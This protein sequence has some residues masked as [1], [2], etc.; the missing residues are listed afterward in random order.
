MALKN[1]HGQYMAK[2]RNYVGPK[3][4][5]YIKE[6]TRWTMPA[7]GTYVVGMFRCL[8]CGRPFSAGLTHVMSGK[9]YLCNECSKERARIKMSRSRIKHHEGDYVGNYHVLLEERLRPEDGY[10]DKG[11]PHGRF[12]CPLC[13]KT[14]TAEIGHVSMDRVTECP[15]CHKWLTKDTLVGRIINNIQ[16]LNYIGIDDAKIRQYFC[17]CLEC[18]E[19][20]QMGEDQLIFTDTPPKHDCKKEEV[21]G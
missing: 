2:P 12:R 13:G 10:G 9:Q 14:F 8:Q 3:N 4:V 16:V 20:F 21:I 15:E 19:I 11:H 7:G 6:I 18:N 1:D 5:Y 17:R